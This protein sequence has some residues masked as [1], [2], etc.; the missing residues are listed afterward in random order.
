M[1]GQTT[2]QMGRAGNGPAGH[3]HHQGFNQHWQYRSTVDPEELFRK[4][5]GDANFTQ[6]FNDYA[7]SKYGFGASQEVSLINFV[8]CCFKNSNDILLWFKI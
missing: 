7:E 5:F 3:G 8:K 1:Y 2:E 6:D 4:I